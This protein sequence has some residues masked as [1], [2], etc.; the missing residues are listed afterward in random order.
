[1]MGTTHKATTREYR[2]WLVA[3]AVALLLLGHYAAFAKDPAII[4]GRD[5]FHPVFA[6]H[7]MVSS[8]E[9]T[10]TDIGVEILKKGGNA[11]DAAV[12][13]GFAL[14]VTLPRAGNIGGG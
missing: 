12:A 2:S 14:A 7:G 3:S 6:R 8:Q 5:I 4:S 10:A 13:V 1:M 11:V 9:A